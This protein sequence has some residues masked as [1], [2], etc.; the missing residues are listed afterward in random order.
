MVSGML[1]RGKPRRAVPD[2]SKDCRGSRACAEILFARHYIPVIK[3][4]LHL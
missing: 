1:L 3:H 2:A 4:T